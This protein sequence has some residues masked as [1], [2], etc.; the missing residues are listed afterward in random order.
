M[1]EIIIMKIKKFFYSY[2]NQSEGYLFQLH[3]IKCTKKDI[4]DSVFINK[5]YDLLIRHTL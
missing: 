2:K 4:F 5:S 1:T 3:K